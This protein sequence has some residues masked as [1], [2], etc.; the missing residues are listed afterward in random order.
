LV[1]EEHSENNMKRLTQTAQLKIDRRKKQTRSKRK[2]AIL[3][4]EHARLCEQEMLELVRL[5]KPFTPT[6][7]IYLRP[8]R[9][10]DA[11][12]IA[13]IYNHYVINSHI[14]EDQEPITAEDVV[15]MI[16]AAQKEKLPFIV[17]ISGNIPHSYGSQSRFGGHQGTEFV[18]QEVVVG[19]AA[20]EIYNF[21]WSGARKG[22]SRSTANLQLFVSPEYV[23]HGIG[24]N[25]LDRLMFTL[26]PTYSF[27]DACAWW[28]ADCDRTY[29]NGGAGRWHQLVF[30]L[31]IL[32][33]DDPNLGWVTSFLKKQFF[34]NLE[35]VH[36][37]LGR[38]TAGK[39]IPVF[40][41]TAF[42]QA[43]SYQAEAYFD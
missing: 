6:I 40:T 5:P 41:D 22:R 8:A 3:A 28:N 23:R 7:D 31:P 37:S 32:K 34:F 26:R 10:Q 25:L 30:Q 20:A 24:R 33:E 29:E 42:F 9:V 4:R 12:Q 38:T 11:Q 39:G 35:N 14:T 15:N 2:N 27:M 36:R 17:A 21:G 16:C 1:D 18:P 19:F 43:D 13:H